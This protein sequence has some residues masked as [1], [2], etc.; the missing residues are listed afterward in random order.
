MRNIAVQASPGE[1]HT[2]NLF[3]IELRR[4]ALQR[5]P[6]DTPQ[7]PQ[8]DEPS[9]DVAGKELPTTLR[10]AIEQMGACLDA[11]STLFGGQRH[12]NTLMRVKVSRLVSL[13]QVAAN[14]C[15]KTNE[16]SVGEAQTS[17]SLV[18]GLNVAM[19]L[20]SASNASVS[21]PNG[22]GATPKRQRES[23]S[24]QRRTPPKKPKSFSQN[25]SKR[26]VV[27]ADREH[28]KDT[29]QRAPPNSWT[30]VQ[31]RQQSHKRVR[32][33]AITVTGVGD[34]SYADMLRV[35]K[36]D[37]SLKHLSGDVQGVRKTA[38]GDLLLRLSKKPAHS[39]EELQEAV[40]KALGN[41][42]VVKKLSE[43]SLL[44]IRDLDELVTKEEVLEAVRG[45][46]N[47]L[48][49][50]ID[51][52]RSLRA[53]R[54]GSQIATLNMPAT[55]A[56]ALAD[57]GKIRIGWAWEVS[58]VYTASDHAAI[59]CTIRNRTGARECLPPPQKAYRADTFNTQAFAAAIQ[60]LAI[61]G[62]ADTMATQMAAQLAVAC[63]GSMAR[64]R[65]YVRHHVPA[66]WWNERIAS[67][68][69]ACL[70][71]R[72]RYT[73]SRGRQTFLE[74]QLEY[75]TARRIL[76]NEIGKSKRECFLELC[77]SAEYDPWGKAYKTVVKR[78][79]AGNQTAP[80]EALEA[81]DGG[82]HWCTHNNCEPCSRN[83]G[84]SPEMERS[85]HFRCISNDGA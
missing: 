60:S 76:K 74:R 32:A 77:D 43:M 10:G 59:L 63:D 81:E 19:A 71:A 15:G 45:A 16:T 39:P 21:Q 44:E 66:Y 17:P 73:R 31:G 49:I 42:A 47:D 7:T 12:I 72:R 65:P 54:D 67:A 82:C 40:G 13:Q 11:L 4:S 29:S 41:R 14:L 85:V 23:A 70:H 57:L 27:D 53:M 18:S 46:T 8:Q 5:T 69:Q 48:T 24:E 83:A 56:K 9:P 3:K 50:T 25:P 61:T 22:N 84:I 80:T 34:C 1:H 35:V 78:I 20:K 55:K 38:K 75:K 58:D 64:R 62:S 37:P 79:N 36:S 52:I 26:H 30:K 68:R 6:P 2:T 51:M 33:D 28:G